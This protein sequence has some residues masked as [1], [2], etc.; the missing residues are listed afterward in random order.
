[1]SMARSALAVQ[2]GFRPE[3]EEVFRTLN[4][5]VYK[6]A[7]RRLLTT[8]CYAILDP[9]RRCLEYASAGHLY[10]YRISGA[11]QVEALESIAYPLGVRERLRIEPRSRQLEP[12]DAIFL[13][14]DGLVESRRHAGE[15]Q[16]GFERLE[17]SLERS[18][19]QDAEAMMSTVLDDVERFVGGGAPMDPALRQREDDLTVLV[20]RLP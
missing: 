16:Y 6:S 15:E 10:P 8:L 19:G 20:L 12:G 2:V 14:S 11:G 13:S 7:R 3:V 4:R 9:Q 18:A 17:E 1:M 5:V